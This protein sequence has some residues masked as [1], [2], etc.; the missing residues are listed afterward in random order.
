MN[1]VKSGVV[2]CILV[3]LLSFPVLA[4]SST[5]GFPLPQSAVETGFEPGPDGNTL[6]YFKI[7]RAWETV[8]EEIRK[9]LKQG[10]WKMD[11]EEISSRYSRVTWIVS[12]K[13]MMKAQVEREGDT[14][15]MTL[16]VPLD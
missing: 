2:F 1:R 4:G 11:S 16:W 10:G 15:T 8:A 3:T 6:V 5:K 12:K 13:I 14:S 7:P 9:N